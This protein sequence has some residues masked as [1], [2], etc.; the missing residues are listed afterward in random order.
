MAYNYL[1]LINSVNR[2][3]NEV[4]LTSANFAS[5]KGWYSQCKDSINASLRDINQSH[6]EWPFNHVIT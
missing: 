6:F 1:E 2:K 3:L 5:A 4:E